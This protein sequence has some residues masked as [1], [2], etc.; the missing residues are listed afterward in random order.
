MLLL[1]ENYIQTPT[2]V[3]QTVTS[4]NFCSLTAHRKRNDNTCK[5]A[6][7]YVGYVGYVGYVEYVEYVEYMEYVEYVE[8]VGYVGYARYVGIYKNM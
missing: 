7:W 3:R 2:V 8:Y 4:V 5:L 1:I 6:V